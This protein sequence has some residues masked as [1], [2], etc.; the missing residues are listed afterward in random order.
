METTASIFLSSFQVQL[1]FI[2]MLTER[3]P[4]LSMDDV[5]FP[6]SNMTIPCASSTTLH[7]SPL[8][9]L[10]AGLAPCELFRPMVASVT[11]S[12]KSP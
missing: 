3:M 9:H 8:N 11:R 1:T 6:T 10:N 12:T 7:E 2:G 4:S 5:Q